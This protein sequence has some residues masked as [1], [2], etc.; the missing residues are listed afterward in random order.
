[1][2]IVV[3]YAADAKDP[4]PEDCPKDVEDLAPDDDEGDSG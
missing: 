1:M 2:R 4:E 3:A